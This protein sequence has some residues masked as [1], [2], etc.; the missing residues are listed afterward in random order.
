MPRI[1]SHIGAAVKNH[2]SSRYAAS[3]S[4]E[5]SCVSEVVS[6]S[7]RHLPVTGMESTVFE[8]KLRSPRRVVF[9][10]QQ[11]TLFAQR[12]WMDCRSTI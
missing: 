3:D 7:I 6:R 1:L 9:R 12:V 4:V 11:Y 2:G 5:V 8:L 10:S